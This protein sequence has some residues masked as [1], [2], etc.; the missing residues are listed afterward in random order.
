MEHPAPEWHIC[1]GYDDLR[2]RG[3]PIARIYWEGGK[4]EVNTRCYSE[5]FT[6]THGLGTVE[7]ARLFVDAWL[8]KWGA[9]AMREVDNKRGAAEAE[10][11]YRASLPP[12]EIK[13]DL[14]K[15]GRGRK[16]F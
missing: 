3:V 2:Y 15:R 11:A 12:V 9:Q 7:G 13:P 14:R 10:A 8:R 5:G 1:D 4:I 6:R 16:A